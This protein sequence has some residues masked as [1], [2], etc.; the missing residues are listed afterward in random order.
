MKRN[1]RIGHLV[2]APGPIKASAAVSTLALVLG[3]CSADVGRF[4]F[5]YN[6]TGSAGATSSLPTPPEPMG[7]GG[8]SLSAGRDSRSG[9]DAYYPDSPTS[10]GTRSVDMSALPEPS[11]PRPAYGDGVRSAD[12]G[13]SRT[14]DPPRASYQQP[15]PSYRDTRPVTEVAGATDSVEVVRGDTLY[16]IS[17]RHGVTVRDLM[18]ANGLTS[19]SIKPGQRLRLPGG[20]ASATPSIAA[21]RAVTT[22]SPASRAPSYASAAPPAPGDESWTGAYQVQSGDSLYRIA[23]QH[24]VRVA[25]LQRVNN[26]TNPRQLRPGVTLRVP[27][28]AAAP[29]AST[30]ARRYEPLPGT[31]PPISAT[32]PIASTTQPTVIN[33][34]APRQVAAL[35]RGRMTDARPVATDTTRLRWPV[36]G[37]IL[38]GFGQ[39]SDGTHNDGINL[40]VPQGAEVHAAEDGEVAYA[41]S[42]L[43][44]YGNLVLVR[45]DNGWVT[46]YAHN[47]ALLVK[48]GDKIRRGDVIAKAGRTGTVDQPQLHFELRQGSKPVDPLPYLERL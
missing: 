48:R 11:S 2:P 16:S 43:K 38:S 45:H 41:G 37:K 24:R 40:A 5:P 32:R 42:E 7:N 12:Y 39:R 13:T 25:D 29:A 46:A 21:P 10:G 35:E 28:G 33:G 36:R 6:V 47:D 1:Q 27:G 20:A 3:A 18:A 30:A 19:P 15:A 22:P 17:R 31:P 34:G 23:R 9:G 44:G 26:I 14:Y 8:A 4:D